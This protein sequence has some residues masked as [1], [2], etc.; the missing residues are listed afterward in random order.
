MA[1][2][3]ESLKELT[4][5]EDYRQFMKELLQQLPEDGCPIYVSK[6]KI[7][8][9]IGGKPWRGVAVLAGPKGEQSVRKLKKDGVQFREGTSRREGKDLR[10]EGIDSG[11]LKAAGVTL[12]KLQLGWSILGFTGE[13]VDVAELQKRVTKLIASIKKNSVL[14]EMDPKLGP[15]LEQASARA[16]QAEKLLKGPDPSGAEALIKEGEDL[17]GRAIVGVLED[18]PQPAPAAAATELEARRQELVDELKDAASLEEPANEGVLKQA[19]TKVREVEGA[20]GK[21]DFEQA[22][23]LL[24]ETEDLLTLIEEGPEADGDPDLP[25]LGDWKAY[26]GFVKAHLKRLPGEGGPIFVSKKKFAFVIKNKPY[27]GYAVLIGNK[28]RVTMQ[29]L[30]KDGV[31]F[32]EGTCKKDGKKLL[33]GGI[34]ALLIKGAAK[35][36]LKLRVGR[37]IVPHGVL[38]PDDEPQVSDEAKQAPAP[39]AAQKMSP[40]MVRKVQEVADA[41]MKLR[42]AADG[43]KKAGVS[44]EPFRSDFAKLTNELG[45]TAQAA[46]PDKEKEAKLKQLKTKVVEKTLDAS[47]AGLDPADPKTGPLIEKQLKARFGVSFKFREEKTSG[48]TKKAD[49]KKEGETLKSLYQT[50]AKCPVFPKSHLTKIELT[51]RPSTA[52]SEGGVYYEDDKLAGIECKRPKDSLDYSTQLGSPAYFPDGVEDACKPA[53]SDPV[54]YFNWA[55]LHEVAHAVDAKNNFM[56]TNGGGEKYGSWTEYG[57]NVAPIAKV[58]AA[59]FGAGLTDPKD[60]AALE[61]HAAA[62]MK[63]KGIK[64]ARSPEEK[65]KRPDLE[66]WIF[67]VREDKKIWWDGAECNRLAIGGVVYQEAYT[68]GGGQWNSYKLSARKRGIHGY[69][70]RASGEWFAELY[71]AYY[72]E[73]LKPAHPFVPD[74]KNLEK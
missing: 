1:T 62:L 69:Q 14:P 30:K 64:P 13:E 8:F 70:F 33:V 42:E 26:R 37:K 40:A 67:D 23:K 72:S 4:T 60:L 57:N 59:H 51:L 34:P 48:G 32:R 68:Y 21:K 61:A 28:G 29:A 73:K 20:L 31:L 36:F 25:G 38:P 5:W 35:T 43:L 18:A 16:S 74:L 10:V 24:D 49:P 11:A 58:V 17:L 46:I 6:E 65:A 22:G 19:A 45:N 50:M 7:D 12:K 55:T 56:G 39:K 52:T 9:E 3:L 44:D 71:A 54:K 47:V 41:L 63:K 53:N 2:T 27:Q 15:L 66:R